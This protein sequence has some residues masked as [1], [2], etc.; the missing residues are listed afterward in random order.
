MPG[1]GRA[2]RVWASLETR[3]G[4]WGTG[5][6]WA[7]PLWPEQGLQQKVRSLEAAGTDPVG[8]GS[9]Q[10][11][12]RAERSR[13]PGAL[14]GVSAVGPP[15]C[16]VTGQA[17]CSH[18][19]QAA[20]GRGVGTQRSG[21]D[22]HRPRGPMGTQQT[23]KPHGAGGS[24]RCGCRRSSDCLCS[25]PKAPAPRTPVAG[26]EGPGRMLSGRAARRGEPTPELEQGGVTA[27]RGAQAGR[28]GP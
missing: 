12:V 14:V 11:L 2:R 3:S 13:H 25:G 8:R 15:H 23:P 5:W 6:R 26:G 28:G 4:E 19:A 20:R 17:S 21:H 18:V 10:G 22:G 24:A 9:A 1:T 27:S 16:Q 7:G